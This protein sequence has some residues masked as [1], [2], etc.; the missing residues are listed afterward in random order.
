MVT[1]SNKR[2][3]NKRKR[4]NLTVTDKEQ[5]L[6]PSRFTPLTKLSDED[7]DCDQEASTAK[8][9]RL[10]KQQRTEGR[11]SRIAAPIFLRLPD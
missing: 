7:S 3:H 10:R 2:T 8:V 9:E 1:T 11:E 6:L 5:E 4:R